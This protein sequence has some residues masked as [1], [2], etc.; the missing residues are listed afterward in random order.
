MGTC[1]LVICCVT[2]HLPLL[3][4]LLLPYCAALTP[5]FSLLHHPWHIL[6][7]YGGQGPGYF[8]PTSNTHTHICAFM[9]IKLILSL[10]HTSLVCAQ[11][12]ARDWQHSGKYA[13]R[14]RNSTIPQNVKKSN[15]ARTN[16]LPLWCQL[17]DIAV[18]INHVIISI[19][20]YQWCRTQPPLPTL[21]N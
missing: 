8:Y 12:H 10:L 4:L 6:C 7:S 9:Y 19:K 17:Q 13:F 20:P 21:G 16:Q 14:Q 3:L 2:K 15:Q 1:S 5:H 11:V 18:N